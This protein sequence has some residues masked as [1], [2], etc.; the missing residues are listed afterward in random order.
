G[1]ITDGEHLYARQMRGNVAAR[2][3]R[4][5]LST[6]AVVSSY[7]IRQPPLGTPYNIENKTF[8]P[9]LLT[10]A[11]V[12]LDG[13][14]TEAEL[15]DPLTLSVQRRVPLPADARNSTG[16]D[17][18]GA[19]SALWIGHTQWNTDELAGKQTFVGITQLQPDGSLRPSRSVP[20]CGTY[21]GY[22][23]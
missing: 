11:V 23:T 14:R 8:S 2:F 19:A 13:D 18:F 17:A 7:A 6:G 20:E 15:L 4:L 21:G 12:M 9:G 22:Q 1:L 5:N 3:V 16:G 10:H